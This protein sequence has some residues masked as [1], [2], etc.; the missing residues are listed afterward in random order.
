MSLHLTRG[1][2]GGPLQYGK[3]V[4]TMDVNVPGVRSPKTKRKQFFSLSMLVSCGYCN[5]LPQTQ[6]IKT[7]EIY[8]LTVL[9]ARSL[10]S[11]YQNNRVSQT[12]QGRIHAKLLLASGSNQHSH[13]FCGLWPHHSNLCLCLH[14]TFFSVSVSFPPLLPINSL[15]LNLGPTQIIV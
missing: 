5:K 10:K 9:E 4:C 14:T 1:E 11:R 13:A 6:W 3:L 8:S 12:L 7:I 15:E 2:T